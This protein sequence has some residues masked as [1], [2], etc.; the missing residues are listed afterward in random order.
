M[1]VQSAYCDYSDPEVVRSLPDSEEST[2]SLLFGKESAGLE[3][4]VLN[5]AL[6]KIVCVEEL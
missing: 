3:F 4:L 1:S 6:K 2:D 5:C